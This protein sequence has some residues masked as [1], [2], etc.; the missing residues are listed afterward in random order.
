MSSKS[1]I[2]LFLLLFFGI[3]NFGL[4]SNK[5]PSLFSS[6][7]EE[8]SLFELI[9]LFSESECSSNKLLSFIFSLFNSSTFS[10]SIS[11]INF[12]DSKHI[13]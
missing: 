3:L 6:S 12:K 4:I 5:E 2:N 9:E 7:L 8:S 1:L 11:T 10:I 13:L